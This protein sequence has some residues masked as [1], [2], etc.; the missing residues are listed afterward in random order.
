MIIA[1]DEQ[2]RE[3]KK[4]RKRGDKRDSKKENYK[5]EVWISSGNGR[6]GTVDRY[7]TGGENDCLKNN[8]EGRKERLHEEKL[9][10]LGEK[11]NAKKRNE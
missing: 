6:R 7:T 9:D 8:S 4:G 3:S 10:S 5:K 2:Q 1:H 11:R